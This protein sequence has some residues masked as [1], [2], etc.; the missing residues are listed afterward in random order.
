MKSIRFCL[1]YL[2]FNLHSPCFLFRYKLYSRNLNL[3][4]PFFDCPSIGLQ[5]IEKVNNLYKLKID[6]T[7]NKSF[8]ILNWALAT[9]IFGF[10][11]LFL[12]EFCY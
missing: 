4:V 7:V 8:N 10:N 9:F 6:F 1:H 2:E 5:N 3:L 11:L 12:V